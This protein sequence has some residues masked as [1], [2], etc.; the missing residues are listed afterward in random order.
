[1]GILVATGAIP[2]ILIGVITQTWVQQ[3]TQE[4]WVEQ[5]QIW[6][7]LLA[8]APNLADGTAVYFVIPGYEDQFGFAN[9]QRLPLKGN[10]EITGALQSL[11]GNKS[12]YGDVIYPQFDTSIEPSLCALGIIPIQKDK[13]VPYSQ[14][15]FIL[16]D[17]KHKTLKVIENLQND[18]TLSWPTPT[19]KPLDHILTG[20]QP[21]T[22]WRK[23]LDQ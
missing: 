1:M 3:N 10:W 4:A 22:E 20:Q 17:G 15:L 2:F 21:E 16:F 5:K 13:L 18:L 6:N 7:E 19:Y 12:L 14:A 23:L 11:Y 8:L 9:W